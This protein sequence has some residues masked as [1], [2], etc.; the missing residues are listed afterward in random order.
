M[1]G[2]LRPITED[3]VAQHAELVWFDGRAALVRYVEEG[4]VVV[5]FP[6]H[7]GLSVF[8]MSTVLADFR[9]RV[10]ESSNADPGSVGPSP[11]DATNVA[12]ES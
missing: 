8:P 2:N 3:D 12:G 7:R 4:S 9:K 1:K 10:P 6:S 5:K 11:E